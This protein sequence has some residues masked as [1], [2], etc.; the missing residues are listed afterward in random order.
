MN[1]RHSRVLAPAAA[2]LALAA[3]SLGGC[4]R[5]PVERATSEPGTLTLH[6]PCVIS[7]PILKV[8][9]AY[10]EA[11][12]EIELRVETDKPLA[13][14]GE[15]AKTQESAAVVITMGDVEMGWLIDAGA[16]RAQSVRTFAHNTYPL[17]VVS[18]AA[19]EGGL[20]TLADLKRP[21]VQRI[22]LEDPARS[23]L[24]ARAERALKELGLWEEI[25]GKIVRPAPDSMVLA[26]ITSGEADAAVVF[27]GC[28]F[29]G[30]N[31]EETAPRTIRII[32]ELPGA[33]QPPIPYLAAP[34][35]GAPDPE[36]A[37]SFV[38]FMTGA[39]GRAALER[40]GLAPP[41]DKRPKAE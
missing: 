14:L 18:A 20:Q 35:A 38:D 32:G 1:H 29:A 24:G 9:G 13:A 19:A 8:V 5:A 12:P 4:Q 28:L 34:L 16:V 36:V 26:A 10:Q 17:V 39:G 3:L 31:G 37:E 2:A 22:H 40:A 6:V 11:H 23:T 27:R 33:N 41:A 15:A 7:G 21:D 25:A 30:A